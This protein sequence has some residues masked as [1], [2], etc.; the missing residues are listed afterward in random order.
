MKNIILASLTTVV[1]LANSAHAQFSNT[2]GGIMLGG[3][4]LD[5]PGQGYGFAQIR[6]TFYEDDSFAHTAFL[7]ILIH[8]DDATLFFGTPGGVVAEDGDITFVNITA[9]YEL[10]AKLFGPLSL[11]AGAGLGVEIVSIDDRFDFELDSDTNFVAQAFV[12]LRADFGNGFLIQAGARYIMRD[13][14]EILGD[15]F[16]TEDTWAYEIGAG[17][18]F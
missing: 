17:F 5:N 14:F 1:L 13:D 16:I 3:G 9:N 18:Q 10:E 2:S 11:Y 12:G 15:Q 6:G 7:D 4:Y 8:T